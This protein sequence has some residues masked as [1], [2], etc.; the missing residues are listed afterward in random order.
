VSPIINK[1][2]DNIVWCDL[3]P[4]NEPN[5]ISVYVIIDRKISIIETGPASSHNNLL[6]GIKQI[7]LTPE[8]I[9]YIIPTHIHLDH[10][11]GGGHLMEICKNAKSI[12]HPNAYKH[13]SSIDRWW[14]GSHDFLGS[15]ADLYGKPKPISEERL[16]SAE[17]GFELSLGSRKI[18]ALHTPGHAPHHITWIYGQEAFVGDSAGLWYP[19]IEYSFPVTPG[20]YRHD[21]ALE[22]IEKMDRLN[23]DFIHYTHF[24]PR[25]ANGVFRKTKK[26]FELWMEIVEKGY[27]Q[28]KSSTAILNELLDIRPGLQETHSAHGPHQTETHLG[29][30][31][32]MKNWIRRKNAK[33]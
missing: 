16:I 20:Y 18:K 30:V 3:C 4:N 7:G 11:G 19:N 2:S 8:D 27:H 6:A 23:L 29:T 33:G 32:G 13:V 21:L 31:E 28:N 14:S 15:I 12:V 22:S 25:P 26:E 10:F 24:G 5:F 1:H 17:D 9:D